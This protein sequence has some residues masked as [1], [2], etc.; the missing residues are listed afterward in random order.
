[1]C[2]NALVAHADDDSFRPDA[3]VFTSGSPGVVAD[4]LTAELA[5]LHAPK[6]VAIELDA[7]GRS[8][9]FQAKCEGKATFEY[10]GDDCDRTKAPHC[11][12][13]YVLYHASGLIVL[14]GTWKIQLL[15]LSPS[16]TNQVTLARGDNPLS[17]KYELPKTV[18]QKGD[19][20]L[21]KAVTDWFA[22]G[23]LTKSAAP[24]TVAVAGTAADELAMS[25]AARKLVATWNK[26]HL[27]LVSADATVT[28][29]R[30]VVR[31]V[32]RFQSKKKT[33]IQLNLTVFAIK[34][35]G[36]WKWQLLDFVS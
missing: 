22:S 19:A 32:V 28:G 35:G 2:E 7:S 5:N 36:V 9:W 10:S 6:T 4:G 14:D 26:M 18:E 21:A 34:D 33:V 23:D 12:R 16:E 20:E 3:T 8:A 29:D 11:D 30:G 31:V 13:Y 15:A 27:A 1:M 24:G 17:P 25:S